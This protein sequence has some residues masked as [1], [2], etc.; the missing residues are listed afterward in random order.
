MLDYFPSMSVQL[1]PPD[2][3][4]IVS[5]AVCVIVSLAVCVLSDPVAE[6]AD[7]RA[8]DAE[9]ATRPLRNALHHHL[10][11]SCLGW[12]GQL[13]LSQ[14]HSKQQLPAWPT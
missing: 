11:P 7:Q 6:Q 3:C 5:H 13:L 2:V 4:G 10:H 12:A 1:F 14:P 9:P 8:A